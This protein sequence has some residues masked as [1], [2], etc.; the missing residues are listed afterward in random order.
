[1]SEYTDDIA[2][3]I[4]DWPVTYTIGSTN[5]T[6]TIGTIDTGNELEQG[7]FLDDVD[8]VLIAKKLDHS[9]VPSIGTKITIAT[10]QYRITRIITMPA[11]NAELRFALQHATK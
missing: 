2:E 11:D 1:M 5:Y 4:S 10:V 7:G 6:G 8:A 9:T 3:M